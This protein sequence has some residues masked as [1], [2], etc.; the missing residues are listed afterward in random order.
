MC[1][2]CKIVADEIPSKK[3]LEDD[4]FLAFHDINPAAPIHILI[5]P[6]E[7]I[8]S[9]N[10]VDSKTMAKMTPFIQKV[11]KELGVVESGYKLQ[12]NVGKG[13]GQEIF[14]LH[15]HLLANKSN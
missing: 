15:F 4:N 10:E 14:H 11:A 6:K 3:V 7:H 5:I 12:T 9:F 1:I 8:E 2:F 13:G